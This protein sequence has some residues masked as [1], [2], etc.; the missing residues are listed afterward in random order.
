MQ[1]MFRAHMGALFFIYPIMNNE[2]TRK[3]IP[4]TTKNTAKPRGSLVI[5]H[6]GPDRSGQPIFCFSNY[7]LKLA[8]YSLAPNKTKK[9]ALGR[10]VIDPIFFIS[11]SG[12]QS[13]RSTRQ[14]VFRPTPCFDGACGVLRLPE[15]CFRSLYRC[16]SSWS[17]SHSGA[18][19][20]KRAVDAAVAG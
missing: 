3:K 14:A 16:A 1:N 5:T 18:F 13:E 11:P 15:T 7:F 17:S 10:P 4:K 12:C 19:H 9:D 2:L 6:I 8:K 20:R